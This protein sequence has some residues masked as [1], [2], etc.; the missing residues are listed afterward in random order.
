MQATKFITGEKMYEMTIV[1]SKLWIF[2]IFTSNKY[3]P[4]KR[5]LNKRTEILNQ[6]SLG[7]LSEMF[8]KNEF[9]D[10]FILTLNI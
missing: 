2:T 3:R 8:R 5:Q 9:D 7:Q 10:L 4:W 6:N 1:V